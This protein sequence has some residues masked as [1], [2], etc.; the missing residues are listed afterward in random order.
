MTDTE[1][2]T[3][4]KVDWNY[5]AKEG[6]IERINKSQIIQAVGSKDYC[7]A[8]QKEIERPTESYSYDVV[9]SLL[10]P[11]NYV[12]VQNWEGFYD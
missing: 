7:L 8:I 3:N 6:K 2:R 12:L 10:E 1:K 9:P 11:G 5:Y 4:R